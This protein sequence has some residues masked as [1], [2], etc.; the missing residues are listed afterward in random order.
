MKFNFKNFKQNVIVLNFKIEIGTITIGYNDNAPSLS[1]AEATIYCN[2]DLYDNFNIF[3]TKK[4]KFRNTKV[5]F[6]II[7]SEQELNNFEKLVKLK[8]TNSTVN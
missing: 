6:Y 5:Q 4:Y 7:G 1:T 2:K 8:T 3:K